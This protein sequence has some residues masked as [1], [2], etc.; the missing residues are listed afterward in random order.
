MGSSL[1]VGRSLL[2]LSI[3]T[4]FHNPLSKSIR[5]KRKQDLGKEDIYIYMRVPSKERAIKSIQR[6]LFKKNTK[7]ERAMEW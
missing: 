2:V 6:H 7:I 1:W 3:T 4:S 5:G